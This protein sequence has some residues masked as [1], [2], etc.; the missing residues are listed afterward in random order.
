MRAC[1]CA[2][3]I[4]KQRESRNVGYELAR[5]HYYGIGLYCYDITISVLMSND[6]AHEMQ[7]VNRTGV[8]EFDELDNGSPYTQGNEQN[9]GGNAELNGKILCMY[10]RF[11][12][13]CFRII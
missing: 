8:D 9:H 1:I 4:R 5:R 13:K 3:S 10:V 7:P 11:R 12:L 2:H 6:V